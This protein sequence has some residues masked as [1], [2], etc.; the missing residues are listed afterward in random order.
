MNSVDRWRRELANLCIF[1]LITQCDN[2]GCSVLYNHFQKVSHRGVWNWTL[3]NDELLLLLVPLT[4]TDYSLLHYYFLS[5]H[6]YVGGIN[7]VV[8]IISFQYHSSYIH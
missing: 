5:A 7:I 2:D 1:N 8:F 4:S 3:S 6:I